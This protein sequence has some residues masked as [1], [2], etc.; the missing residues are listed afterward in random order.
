M[1]ALSVAAYNV[2]DVLAQEE[3]EHVAKHRLRPA[4]LRHRLGCVMA[5]RPSAARLRAARREGD[6]ARDLRCRHVMREHVRHRALQAAPARLGLVAV[7][8]VER[9]VDA[10]DWLDRAVVRAALRRVRLA[11]CFVWSMLARLARRKRNKSKKAS[12]DLV[13][14]TQ[15]ASPTTSLSL[16]T[17]SRYPFSFATR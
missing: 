5:R 16:F 8:M 12:L 13:Y 14:L 15:G 4:V 6:P 2:R 3:V 1:T 11:S 17:H 10:R 9:Q 7:R